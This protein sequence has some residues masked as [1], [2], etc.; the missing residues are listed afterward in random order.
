MAAEREEGS[1]EQQDVA[2]GAAGPC[3][4]VLW[5]VKQQGLIG[6]LSAPFDFT[7]GKEEEKEEKSLSVSAQLRS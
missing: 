5:K 1:G 4:K 6:A 2:G 3:R 7:Q